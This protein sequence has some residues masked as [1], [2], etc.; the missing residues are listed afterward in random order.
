MITTIA[1]LTARPGMP[2]EECVDYYENRHVPL[3]LSLAPP[4]LVYSRTY[5]PAPED[6]RF[7]ADFES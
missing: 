1:L 2:C 7:P 3:I 4:P 5:L 6:R